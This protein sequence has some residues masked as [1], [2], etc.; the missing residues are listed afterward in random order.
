MASINV[1][2]TNFSGA[3]SDP[4]AEVHSD[5]GAGPAPSTRDAAHERTTDA[6]AD[7]SQGS[8]EM[9]DAYRAA[10][11]SLDRQDHRAGQEGHGE[12]GDGVA[13][14]R[15]KRARIKHGDVAP[16]FNPL[17]A[18]KPVPRHKASFF[19]S[20]VRGKNGVEGGEAKSK[21]RSKL[22][23]STND[24]DVLDPSGQ[25][26]AR[27]PVPT[28]NAQRPAGIGQSRSNATLT[29]HA[30]M[31]HGLKPGGNPN[32]RRSPNGAARTNETVGK[33]GKAATVMDRTDKDILR[34]SKQNAQPSSDPA[35]VNAAH[36][37]APNTP[38]LANA[39]AASTFGRGRPAST[40][41][42]AQA[43]GA[44]GGGPAD[45]ADTSLNYRFTSWRGQPDVSIRVD[46][47]QRAYFVQAKSD[48]DRI[49]AAMQRHVDA[50]APDT[51]LYFDAQR[52]DGQQHRSPWSEQQDEAD[53]Q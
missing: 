21:D 18:A 13:H 19:S 14:G 9:A 15:K 30:S 41:Q 49:E 25:T 44:E 43:A 6:G 45:R 3:R 37:Q 4:S 16:A 50:L 38:G 46:E 36:W 33:S 2:N 42:G 26:K 34:S 53:E 17:V 31:E 5:A 7:P 8:S 11:R 20:V 51:R 23:R 27:L 47:Q 28:A 24:P 29:L 52:D 12:H 32:E 48:R 22:H 1:S 40:W 39:P 10:C 35:A